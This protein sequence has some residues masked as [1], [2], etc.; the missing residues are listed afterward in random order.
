M[1]KTAESME[2]ISLTSKKKCAMALVRILNPDRLR[3]LQDNSK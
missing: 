1:P 3:G 2:T